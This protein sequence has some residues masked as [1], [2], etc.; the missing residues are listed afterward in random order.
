MSVFTFGVRDDHG[1]LSG[2]QRDVRERV[3][4]EL[5]IEWTEFQTPGG[6]HKS[7]FSGPNKG[8]PFDA[9]LQRDATRLVD[10]Y[11]TQEGIK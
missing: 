3:A 9:D 2:R 6:T 1:R 8:H 11:E 5:G 4:R 7:Y 10:L